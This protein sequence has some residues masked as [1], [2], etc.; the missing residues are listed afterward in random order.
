[1]NNKTNARPQ[2]KYGYKTKS[3]KADT[4]AKYLKYYAIGSVVILIA[5][6]ILLNILITGLFGDALTF[7]FSANSQN[8]ITQQSK[9]YIDSLP[10]NAHIRIVGL[11]DRPE[12]LQNSPYEYIVPLLDDYVAESGGRITV[13]YK[14]P[15]R[16]PSIIAELDPNSVFELEEGSYVVQYNDQIQVINPLDCFTIDQDYYMFY[17][18]YLPTSNNV[19]YVF[20]NT[21]ARLVSGFNKKAYIISGLQEEYST[22]ITS[23]LNAL[24]CD[25][26]YIQV[27]AGFEIP[28][29]CDLLI[30][31]GPDTDITE[32]VQV[33]IENYLNE[34]G[35]FICAVN[36]T[37]DNSSES[38][39]NLNAVLNKMNVNIDP[40]VIKE[41]DV[42]YTLDDSGYNSLIA[43]NTTFLG[44]SSVFDQYYQFKGSYIR[45]VR[46]VDENASTFYSE[47]IGATSEDAVCV[48]VAD[49]GVTQYGEAG[50][51]FT[52]V[53]SAAQGNSSTAQ[54]IVFGTTDF[55]SDSYIS[56]YGMNDDN[57]KFFKA[58]ARM[59]LG[60]DTNAAVE[61]PT[62]GISDYKLN[63]ENV[64][65]TSSTVVLAV[66]MVTIP[67]VF[68][69]AAAVVYE[70]RKNL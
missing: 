60:S 13:E 7:D 66:F 3:V 29:D 30:L 64:T 11:L 42:N 21:I 70:L 44:Q 22:S 16:Y 14:N 51:F 8:T 62:R 19:E 26:E 37:D 25:V 43:V 61:V 10:E 45:P 49:T 5:I 57:I 9:D 23:I 40:Y 58:C 52:A 33:E 46:I 17:N 36:F 48:K 12:D 34:G 6:V 24:G 68:L 1:M 35:E 27:T 56:S 54:V 4:R 15:D 39:T 28:D 41:N 67:L 18:A 65:A 20:T 59:L 69:V 38:Y 50:R 2:V 63:G 53:Y 31:N 55:M 32:K 47:A